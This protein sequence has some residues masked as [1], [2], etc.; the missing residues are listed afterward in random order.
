VT[1]SI[2][3]SWVRPSVI[4]VA[5]DLSDL[6]R[7]MPVAFE[8]TADSGARLILLHVLGSPDL[9]SV[10]AA[11][12]PCYDPAC[13]MESA[14]RMLESCCQTARHQ[15]IHCD[16]VL[17][18]G[19]VAQQIAAVS[20]QF[21]ADRIILG[22]RTRSR[23]GKPLL[24]SVVEQVLRSV[25]LPVMTVGPEAHL[26]V[27][28]N[29]RQRIVL[30]ATTLRETSRPSAALA[31]L[32]AAHQGARLVLLHVL[33]PVD[34]WGRKSELDEIDWNGMES[35]ALRELHKLAAE[36]CVESCA[37]IDHLVLRGNPT[38]EILAEA[39]GR[40]ASLIVLGASQHT[41]FNDLTRDQVAMR[42]IAYAHCP[43]LILRETAAHESEHCTEQMAYHGLS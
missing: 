22:T 39:S 27:G 16:M 8:E 7:L 18:E 34:E 19:N 9:L 37:E 11:G 25:N 26:K 43:V 13:F 5:T 12:M 17:R 42:V 14:T 41:T 4:L 33:P 35:T 23:I 20:R 36:S 29:D 32:I 3:N 28:S 10:D 24:G 1:D 31:S 21:H 6:D 15:K 38:I 30:H 2:L 40:S